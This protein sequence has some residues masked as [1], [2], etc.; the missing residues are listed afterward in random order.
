MGTG[1]KCHFT[2]GSLVRHRGC[3][4][5]HAS[6]CFPEKKPGL[7]ALEIP[8]WQEFRCL[9]IH[10]L[11]ATVTATDIVLMPVL[12]KCCWGCG[13]SNV[14]VVLR[15]EKPS[16]VALPIS[17]Q[18][19][20]C[21]SLPPVRQPRGSKAAPAKPHALAVTASL[22]AERIRLLSLSK[23]PRCCAAAPSHPVFGCHYL[24]MLL[25]PP[26]STEVC[27]HW[28]SAHS[29]RVFTRLFLGGQDVNDTTH[30]LKALAGTCLLFVELCTS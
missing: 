16:C 18:L 25:I 26:R 4:D 13:E 2:V 14:K 29:T 10:P 20:L 3:T 19:G 21:T 5:Q 9:C 27:S 15:K 30:C 6:S 23:P 1:S 22:L 11:S 17:K 24:N 28:S 8:E 12:P 7:S